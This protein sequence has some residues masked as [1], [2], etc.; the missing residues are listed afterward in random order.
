MPNDQFTA[1]T[2]ANSVLL[3]SPWKPILLLAVFTGWAY[4]V[5]TVFDKDAARW[6]FKRRS[7]NLLH[8][9][10]GGV[11]F[12]AAV[13]APL[14]FFISVPIAMAIL[15][16]D[17]L[18]YFVLRNGDDRVPAHEKWKL[19][20]QSWKDRREAKNLAKD[21][22]GI[23]YT[24]E[25]PSGR[26]LSP[27][28]GTPEF[29]TRV[30]AEALLTH[31]VDK[32]GSQ[33]DIA[34]HRE[35]MYGASCVVDG[36]RTPLEQIPTQNAIPIID[37]FKGAA[38]LDL[39]D[40][41][42]KIRG[43]IQFGVGGSATT[44]A[45]VTSL[46]TSDGMRLTLAIEPS[47]LA[48]KRIED[49]GLLPR[50]RQDLQTIIEENAGI[51][52]VAA[53]AEESR[54][55]LMYAL[56]RAHDAY[57][58]NVQLLELDGTLNIEGARHTIFDPQ[59]ASSDFATTV[60][61][62]LRRDPDVLAIA[63]MPDEETARNVSLADYERTRVYLCVR[64]DN[65][66][67]ALQMYCKAVGDNAA[68]AKGLRGVICQRMLRL[69]S[70]NAR[71]PYQPSPDVLKRLGLPAEVKT[72]YRTEGMVM[73]KGKPEPDPVSGGTGYY[74]QTG[75]LA[76]HPIGQEEQSLIAN[77]DFNNLRASFRQK[78]QPSV[79]NAAMQKAVQG[80]TSVEEVLRVLQSG[81]KKQRKQSTQT[82]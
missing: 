78:K 6:Y 52:I 22:K 33:L 27:E 20:T 61:S 50:Q 48:D 7:W 14:P 31:T 3:L 68:A 35:G 23:M 16:L 70:V 5:S 44:D 75:A 56:A 63:E 67:T 62:M 34:P 58:S 65:P 45:R 19:D 18:I 30:A 37:F 53:P 47:K 80:E 40:R 24:F 26:L 13:L 71:I 57:T 38:D 49:L 73:V 9:I 55:G 12:A 39:N 32:H 11:A 79:Q 51:V 36:L 4:V 54:A 64:A 28:E 10:M 41:R 69:L 17:L 81:Q 72:L 8:L 60:R 42:R 82:A 43:D 1:A 74:G 59:E 2:L 46:G 25:G 77:G 76:V 15:A 29:Q 66:I 21:A